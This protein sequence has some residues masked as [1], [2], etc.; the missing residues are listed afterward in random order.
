[1]EWGEQ[2]PGR[3]LGGF[4]PL[5][6]V[7]RCKCPQRSSQKHKTWEGSQKGDVIR[8]CHRRGVWTAPEALLVLRRQNL[9]NPSPQGPLYSPSTSPMKPSFGDRFPVL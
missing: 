6:D 4:L 2:V 7:Q 8:G 5:N 1:M 9:Q 3:K